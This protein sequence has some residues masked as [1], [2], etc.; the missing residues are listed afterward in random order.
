MDSASLVTPFLIVGLTAGTVFFPGDRVLP[1]LTVADLSAG[2]GTLAQLLAKTA[3]KVIAVDNAPKMVEFGSRLAKQHGFAHL[4]YRLGDIEDPP[5]ANGTVDLAILSQ[6]LAFSR[7][8]RKMRIGI[9]VRFPTQTGG[10]AC[11]G[12]L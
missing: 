1:A 12:T 5:I 7:M 3:R 11:D 9:C 4:E 10:L 8:A 6:A 2:E